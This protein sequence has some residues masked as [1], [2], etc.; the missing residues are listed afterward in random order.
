MM[1]TNAFGLTDSLTHPIPTQIKQIIA[2]FYFP[3][4]MTKYSFQ[5]SLGFELARVCYRRLFGSQ[6]FLK[7]NRLN[8]SKSQAKKLGVQRGDILVSANGIDLWKIKSSE[9]ARRVLNR[10]KDDDFCVSRYI[11]LTLARVPLRCKEK[12]NK[13]KNEKKKNINFEQVH[14]MQLADVADD[15][16]PRGSHSDESI[17]LSPLNE[18]Q[19]LRNL[20]RSRKHAVVSECKSVSSV[21]VA[22]SEGQAMD[23]DESAD[24]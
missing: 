13:K 17:P 3:C 21:A 9:M 4:T 15:A 19:R 23:Y 22:E 8:G 11:T 18:N 24:K 5:R 16:A 14:Q 12:K 10:I 20:N 1:R 7:V 2:Q 6:E